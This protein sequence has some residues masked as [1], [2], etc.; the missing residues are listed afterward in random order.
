MSTGVVSSHLSPPKRT[1]SPSNGQL[2][3]KKPALMQRPQSSIIDVTKFTFARPVNQPKGFTLKPLPRLPA[4]GR[5]PDEQVD[6]VESPKPAARRE[7][8]GPSKSIASPGQPSPEQ[9]LAEH[10]PCPQPKDQTS[11]ISHN[12]SNLPSVEGTSTHHFWKGQ[13]VIG[14]EVGSDTALTTHAV[15]TSSIPATISRD[16][17]FHPVQD[18]DRHA[19]T[20]HS[21]SL[22]RAPARQK[23][24]LRVSKPR[25]ENRKSALTR[26]QRSMSSIKSGLHQLTEDTLFELLIGRIRQREENETAAANIQRRMETKILELKD[27]N[28]DLYQRLETGQLHLKKNETELKK[29]QA[30]LEDWKTKIRKFKQVVDELGHDHDILKEVNERLEATAA[31]LGKE[32]TELFQAIDDAKFQIARAEGRVDEQRK[33]IADKE[34][35]IALLQQALTTAQYQDE[36]TKAELMSERNRNTTLESYI[37]NY[38]LIQAKQIAIIQDNQAKLMQELSA[39]LESIA[40]DAATFKDDILSATRTVFDQCRTSIE[41]LSQSCSDETLRVQ[42]FT[43]STREV[44]SQIEALVVKLTKSFETCNKLN[45]GVSKSVQDSMHSIES[46]ISADSEILQQFAKYHTSYEWLKDKIG[47]IEPT[48]ENLN[49]SVRVMSDSENKLARQFD[50]FGR[51]LE[52]AKM[53]TGNPEFERQMADST[54]LQLNLQKMVSELVSEVDSLKRQTSEKDSYIQNLQQSLTDARETY[55][56]VENQNQGLEIEKTALKGEVE[57]RDQ[58]IHRELITEYTSSQNLMKAQYEQQLR[59]LQAE[60]EELE[61]GAELVITQLSDVQGALIEAKRL[62]DDQRTQ[63]ESLAQ[64]TDQQIQQLNQS[65][66]EHMARVEAQILEIQ[67]YQEAEAASC[68]ERNGLQE[69]LRQ[70]Q[71][72]IHELERTFFVSSAEEEGPRVPPANI[73]PFSALESQLSPLRANSTRG[74]PADFAMLFMSDELLLATPHHNV[75]EE[76]ASSSLQIETKAKEIIRPP[77]VA[78]PAKLSDISPEIRPPPTQAN[79]KRKAVN[80]APR[81][82]ESNGSQVKNSLN[83]RVPSTDVQ[84]STRPEN[85]PEERPAKVTKHINRWTYSRVHAS[86]IEVQKEQSTAPPTRA[87]RGPQRASPKGVVSASSAS[88]AAGRSNTRGR[89][90]RRSRGSGLA[91]LVL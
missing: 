41:T 83:S 91:P 22:P 79:T 43:V 7:N 4:H 82:A 28:Q 73:V 32:K 10:T 71:E 20:V 45:I 42:E 16:I 11:N 17:L 67:K 53:P 70:A 61:K 50:D 88:E 55:K 5:L 30:R 37:Q 87:P 56:I 6:G 63:R 90:K 81:R 66:S 14:L 89:G 23:D 52:E 19:S 34:Q 62:V 2:S 8:K 68:M 39:G 49:A 1:L 3:K 78:D 33:E 86:R 44:I 69:Q 18:L 75:E 80:F 13:E 60:K 85:A 38:A 65:C 36:C 74:D 21:L 15:A 46:H 57:L 27:E 54:K 26:Q 59:I 64:E 48:L 84:S 76:K 47:G 35:R 40:T 25:R 51:K 24:N 12:D 72:R 31:S 77:D 29:Y 58:R 9:Y